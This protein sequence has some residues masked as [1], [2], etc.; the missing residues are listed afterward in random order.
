MRTQ[1]LISLSIIFA[2]WTLAGC[3]T[4][5]PQVAP[6]CTATIQKAVT[7][8]NTTFHIQYLEPAVQANG[9]PLHS[10]SHTTIYTDTGSGMV[11]YAKRAA[12]SPQGGKMVDQ[13]ITVPLRQGQSATVQ[14]CVTATNAIGEGLPTP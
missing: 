9:E 6:R 8:P 1:S 11:E 3:S 13:E 4:L 12:S 14:V 10:L 2:A 5:A 7:H